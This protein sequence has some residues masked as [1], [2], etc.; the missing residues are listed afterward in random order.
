MTSKPRPGIAT[1]RAGTRLS[2]RLLQALGSRE[3]TDFWASVDFAVEAAEGKT[4][5][6][7]SPLWISADQSRPDNVVGETCWDE[8]PI[9]QN[10]PGGKF[11]FYSYVGDTV[12]PSWS[13]QAGAGGYSPL[14]A[15][16]DEPG[17]TSNEPADLPEVLHDPVRRRSWL[18]AK[19]LETHPLDQALELAR[20]AEAFITGSS[21]NEAAGP[22]PDLV[23][24]AAPQPDAKREPKPLRRSAGLTLSPDDRE[25]LLER[26]AQ[27]ARNAE[28]ASQFGLST[29]QV[30]GMRMGSAREI[31]R[32]RDRARENE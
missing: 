24:E 1:H 20:G 19:A 13:P 32:R 17:A 14:S 6:V 2:W 4:P 10:P 23:D 22:N 3:Q 30:Q 5:T 9:H 11:R 28:L 7:R 29:K 27:G 21:A 31:A 26:L 8:A 16:N 25:Q 12:P 18:L 15:E